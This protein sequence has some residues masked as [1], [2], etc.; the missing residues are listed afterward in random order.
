MLGLSRSGYYK[1]LH[2][3]ISSRKS[4]RLFLLDKIKRIHKESRFLYGSPRI[5]AKLQSLGYFCSRKLIS[6]VMRENNI[7]SIIRKS[8]KK[9][10]NSRHNNEISP[11]V[12]IG[13]GN[14]NSP[15]EIWVSDITYV[16]TSKGWLYLTTVLDL[17][18]RKIVGYS[19]SNDMKVESTVLKAFDC[20]V[21][22]SGG[23][24][25]KIFHSDRG[26]QYSSKLFRKKLQSAGITQSMS[27]TGNCYDNA[28]A[29]SFFKTIKSELIYLNSF[30]CLNDA[31]TAIFEYIECFYNKKRI[32]S[33]IGYKTPN[34]MQDEYYLKKYDESA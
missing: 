16:R 34:E 1:W 11:N 31:K 10:T 23:I 17:F 12:L 26:V 5:H 27:S 32:H 8:Y 13:Y 28:F 18:T 24:Y 4:K 25:P 6:S 7:S 22:K 20:A 33:G 9:T 15:Y 29:E 21:L 30:K 3:K 2:K 19:M 14:I